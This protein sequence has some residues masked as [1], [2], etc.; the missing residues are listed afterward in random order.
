MNRKPILKFGQ[1]W[2]DEHS[3]YKKNTYWIGADPMAS[4][5]QHGDG[6]VVLGRDCAS[7]AELESVA[8]DI[9]SDLG[10]VLD[11]ARQKLGQKSN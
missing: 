7:L 5:I 10:R 4:G 9:R 8:A 1:K 11:E 2:S 6:L 3:A